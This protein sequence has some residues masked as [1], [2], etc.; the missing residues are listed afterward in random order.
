MRPSPPWNPQ[1]PELLRLGTV[2]DRDD[3]RR[4]I[5]ASVIRDSRIRTRNSQVQEGDTGNGLDGHRSHTKPLS[6]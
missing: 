3:R 1:L 4:P 6:V 5:R 2:G